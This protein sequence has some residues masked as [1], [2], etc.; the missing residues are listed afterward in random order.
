[1]SSIH[2]ADIFIKNETDGN[3]SIRLYHKNSSFGTSEGTW[4]VNTGE[5]A[6]PLTIHFKT[7]F[8]DEGVLDYWWIL[9]SVMDGSTPGEYYSGGSMLHPDWKE[10]QLQG[11]DDE[12]KLI[13]TVDTKQFHINLMSGSCIDAMS[14]LGPFTKIENVF[15]LMLENHS[16]DNIFAFSGIPGITAATTT[17]SNT[18]KGTSYKAQSGAP[19]NMSTDPGHEFTDVLE[20]LTGQ[21]SYPSGMLY[22][23]ITNSGFVE[24]YAT[25][26]SE[27]KVPDN[28]YIGDV[29]KCFDTEVQ[30]PVIHQL[31]SEF[32]IC[33]HWFSSLPGPTWP[34]RFFIHGAS[35]NGLDHSPST[36]ELLQWET[37]EGFTYEHGSVFEALDKSY[38]TDKKDNWRIYHDTN[39]PITGALPQ[40]AS[41][42][43]I[44][45]LEDIHKF[46]SF[47]DDLQKPYPYK[48]TFIEPNYG[49]V[50][51]NTYTRGSSQH[52]MDGTHGGE[53]LIKDTYEAIRNSPIWETSIL[54]ICYDEHGGFYD[55]VAPVNA[56]APN[57]GSSSKLNK[58][59]F[60]FEQYGVRVPAVVVSPF[61]PKGSVDKTNYDHASVPSTLER[62]FV[63]PSLTDRDR[64]ANDLRHLLSLTAAR[65]DCPTSLSNPVE[66]DTTVNALREVSADIEQQP[67]AD[68]G[69]F[70]GFLFIMLKTELE[71]S[72]GSKEER[73][74]IISEFKKIQTKGD[75]TTYFHSVKQKIENTRVANGIKV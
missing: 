30:L 42:Q 19:D 69:N 53:K 35:S 45:F 43:G 1:M 3:A 73:E 54:I 58:Y 25:T 7:G 31:A 46:S 32:A 2:S 24:N 74:H 22:P 18:Y 64:H 67:M 70:P 37:F 14:Y 21:T 60:N 39:G 52:P 27:G 6:G 63:F 4:K 40:V 72:N 13:F 38:P 9:L 11:K 62:I 34:N 17:D 44:H 26:T 75:A 20:Q 28:K 59:H 10:C 66:P 55:S 61:I 41:L 8:P 16:F 65:T 50:T 48:Y 12:H 71:L 23:A 49:D 57:D 29:M 47:A 36:L 56:V 68:T 15:V 5:T 51:H 33:D